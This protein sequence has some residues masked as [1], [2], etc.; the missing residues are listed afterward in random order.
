MTTFAIF[1]ILWALVIAGL[2]AANH[3]A[4]IGDDR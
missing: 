4:G 3:R 2:L 1:G